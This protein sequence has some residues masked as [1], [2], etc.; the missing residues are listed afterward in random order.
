MPASAK[1][2]YRPE[3]RLVH[4]GQ[5][6]SQFGETS[7]TLFLTQGFVY[8]SA[9]DCAARFKGDDP[10]F[11]YARFSNPTVAMLEAR[12]AAF[13]GAEAARATASGMAAVTAA[14]MGQLRAGDHVAAA[15]QLFGSCRWVIEE[16]LPRFGVVST[17]VDGLELDHWRRAVRAN[18]KT[19]FLE[20]PTNPTLDIIDIAAVARIAHDAGATLI[21]DNVFATPLWQSP[22]ALGADCVVYSATKHIDGQGRCLGGIIL[23]SED[24]I[25]RH[26][27]MLLR[28]TGPSMS[29]F[30][31]WVL[32]K[33]LETLHLRVRRQ[34]DTAA[35][36]A[37][38]LVEH[39]KIRRLI[40]P[41]RPDHPQAAIAASQMRGGSTLVA[42]EIDG[43]RQ[44]AFR[45]LN[46]L[47]LVGITN[48]LG[49]AK[50]LI[51]HPATTTHQRLTPEQR[52]ELGITDGLVRFSAGLEHPDDIVEDLLAALDAV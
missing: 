52:L 43:D 32:L 2:R 7:E 16:L 4:A 40:Y 39:R 34:T 44:A 46:G 11:V 42:F 41:G 20:S 38:A 9:E 3:T 31:A 13:E 35:A 22:L 14:L 45:F 19:F 23:A 29:P 17:L 24:F 49:D 10:G 51:T 47:E 12:M 25:Q 37:V 28:Q 1:R 5:L 26:V 36:V 30:N 8:D 18:T 21:V 33:G 50:S 48:N 15:K 6:R 27:H